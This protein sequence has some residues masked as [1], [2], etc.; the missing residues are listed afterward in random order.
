[1]RMRR[2]AESRAASANRRVAYSIAERASWIEQGP[3]TTSILSSAPTRMRW[4][5]WRA[6]K[7]EAAMPSEAGTSRST[8]SGGESSLISR[9][10]TSS[11]GF[12]TG[13]DSPRAPCRAGPLLAGLRPPESAQVAEGVTERPVLRIRLLEPGAG[14]CGHLLAGGMTG[15]AALADLDW[16]EKSDP[17]PEIEHRRFHLGRLLGV[18]LRQI[19]PCPRRRRVAW[20]A[21]PRAGAADFYPGRRPGAVA[22]GGVGIGIAFS[23]PPFRIA[24][25]GPDRR[26]G[27]AQRGAKPRRRLRESEARR[28]RHPGR[29]Q[30]DGGSESESHR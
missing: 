16:A 10:R 9:M 22:A 20:I 8:W 15:K 24:R 5:P 19:R 1:M 29:G 3:I 14:L 26:L 2:S 18:G 7:T 21:Q 12:I 6:A 4:M 13:R 27:A 30:H 25:G 28:I 11:I 17:I 23:E